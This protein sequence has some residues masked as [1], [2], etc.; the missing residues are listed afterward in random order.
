MASETIYDSIPVELLAG[1]YYHIYK[2]IEKDILSNKMYYE[3]QLIEQT[4]RKKGI[5]LTRLYEI[6]S[7]IM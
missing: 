3:I 1:F 5:C 6:G 2:N 4:A 7:T